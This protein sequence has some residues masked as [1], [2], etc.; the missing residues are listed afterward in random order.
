MC[1]INLAYSVIEFIHMPKINKDNVSEWVSYE[2][3]ENLKSAYSQGRGVIFITA[4]FGN[5]E[6]MAYAQALMGYS[7][8]IVIRP[9]DN[10]YLDKVVK[11]FR[12][13]SGNK[14]IPKKKAAKGILRCL[15]KGQSVGIL[16]DQNVSIGDRVFVDFFGTPASTITAPA[17]FA[18]RTNAAV[19][20]AFIIRQDNG[21]HKVIYEP[22]LKLIQTG[23]QKENIRQN[24]QQFTAQV[25]KYA[26]KYPQ[27]WFWMHRR[28]KTRPE[29]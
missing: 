20:P 18:Q 13:G 5:W 9:L 11:R 16:I 25:E 7:S 23:D 2:G 14:F 15:R 21:K 28:W 24:M 27:Q 26:A 17:I 19:I 12:S 4:H 22:E 3:L 29:K 6:L 10:I 1:Y 8:N